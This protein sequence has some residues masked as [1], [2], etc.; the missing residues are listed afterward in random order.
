MSYDTIL[1]KIYVGLE[2]S[3]GQITFEF[4]LQSVLAKNSTKVFTR[5]EIMREINPY[6]QQINERIIDTHVKNLR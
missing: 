5:K 6:N 1:L 3:W 2:I 4:Q